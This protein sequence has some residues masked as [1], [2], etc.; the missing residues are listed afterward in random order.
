MVLLFDTIPVTLS[1][2]LC[3]ES[4]LANATGGTVTVDAIQVIHCCYTVLKLLLH[5]C[6]TVVTLLL[7][8]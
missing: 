6:Y 5:S 8:C 7:R 2:V 1:Q 3:H 4:G